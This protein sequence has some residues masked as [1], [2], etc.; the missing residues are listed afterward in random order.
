MN[1]QMAKDKIL[2]QKAEEMMSFRTARSSGQL[3]ESQTLRLIHEL[4]VHQIELEL[5]NEELNQA[6]ASERS[7]SEK[8]ITLFDFAPTAYFNL[9]EEGN[10]LELNLSGAKIIGKERESL[11]NTRFSLFIAETSK[12]NFNQF[13]ARV[14]SSGNKENCEIRIIKNKEESGFFDV[15]GIANEDRTQCFLTVIN[16][17]DRKRA[18]LLE[19]SR[20]VFSRLFDEAPL[21]Y[22]SLDH[23][24]NILNANKLW[25]ETFGYT[26][27]EVIGRWFGEFLHP[28]YADLF[29]KRFQYF[30][31]LG[32]IH[33][34]IEMICKN[35]EKRLLAY[36]GRIGLNSDGT[37]KQTHCI[38]EDITSQREIE[39]IRQTNFLLL[40]KAGETAK[41][42]GWS[43]DIPSKKVTWS[44]EVAAIHEM[45]T[46]YSP[47][48]NEGINFYKQDSR[49]RITAVL[50]NC[51][52]KGVP[53]DEELEFVTA[54]NKAIWVRT[55]G[56]AVKDKNGNIFKIQ[57]SF[58]NISE[59]KKT[60]E[61]LRESEERF[62][63]FMNYLPAAAFIK[64]RS[65]K[66]IFA[67]PNLKSLFGWQNP[68]GKQTS[69]L[70]SPEIANKMIAD[71]KRVM[72]NGPEIVHEQ[73]VS[74]QG[75]VYLFETHKFP[76]RK[77]NGEE[78]LG[79]ISIDETERVQAE[80]NLKENEALLSQ[81]NATK[82]KLFSIMTHDLRN[83]FN[84]ILGFSALLADQLKEKKYGDA[85]RYANVILVSAKNAMN[86]LSNLLEW[87]LSQT[88][89]ITIDPQN[90]KLTE[91]IDEVIQLSQEF[92]YLKSIKLNKN[93]PANVFA[94]ADKHMVSI[95]LR[96]LIQ[97]AIKYTNNGGTVNINL[98]QNQEEVVVE[99]TDDGVGIQE[100]NLN[101]LFFVNNNLSTEGTN[102]EKGTGLGLILC[103][104][105]VEKN[106]GKIGVESEVGK[107][108]KFYFTLPLKAPSNSVTTDQYNI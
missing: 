43:M 85:E 88:K 12:E 95:I 61:A 15:T 51:I 25:L 26:R 94:F 27:E 29:K 89:R 64:D 97:N 74:S 46:G 90:I 67:N 103:K 75:R 48:L 65:G 49:K 79:G 4:E 86:L 36:Q 50:N 33:F 6:K 23:D 9:S 35:G 28:E 8:Y 58:Q 100:N 73:I 98:L 66:L 2:R 18:E 76:F 44:D 20:E 37:F 1:K 41:F 32:K 102:N 77:M 17:S 3:S 24:G 5:Q 34:E 78:F 54:K 72:A 81:L 70:L 55:T 96:N 42:G 71:D 106:G 99:V 60:E 57:G 92:A 91:L 84:A 59:R 22:H 21:S 80:L 108:S 56:E 7:I 14:F 101:K 40:R 45:P 10:I 69:D 93:L 53:F 68:L 52:E 13:F 105:F 47:S 11:K 38:L 104:E 83:P 16:I 62:E 39:A 107:G 30:K 82:D 19:E 31:S 63:L 87:S